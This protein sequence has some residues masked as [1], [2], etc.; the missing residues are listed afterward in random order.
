VE[1]NMDFVRVF[2]L[3]LATGGR[4]PWRDLAMP[5]IDTR[6]AAI[7]VIPTPDGKSYVYGYHRLTSD[8]FIAEGLK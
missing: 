8:L 7:V 2:R 3:D 6:L 4:E 1:K 5:G